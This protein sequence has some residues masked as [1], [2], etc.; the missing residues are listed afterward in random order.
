MYYKSMDMNKKNRGA[1]PMLQLTFPLAMEQ[2]FR[3]LVSTADTLM[4]SGY[5]NSA[6]AGVAVTAQYVFF[7]NLIFSVIATGCSI[8]LSQYIGAQKHKEELNHIAQASAVMMVLISIVLTVAVI[9]GTGPILS[10]YDLEPAV[11][12]SAT[13]YFVIFGGICCFFNAFSLLQGSILRTYGYTKE[14][15]I[16]SI[17]ANIINV[18]GNAISI[19]G[20]FGLP[21]TGVAGVAWSS[22]ISMIVSFFMFIYYI[23]RR[24]DV[25]FSLK[26]I[27]NVPIQS[28]RKVLS[29]GIPTAGESLSYNI[30]QIL[31]MKMITGLGT[32]AIAA[33]NYTQTVMR[34]VFAIAISIGNAT[35]IKAG[36]LVGSKQSDVA[37]KKVI[38][39]QL[40]ATACSTSLVI[41]ANIFKN[42]IISLFPNIPELREYMKIL[43]T[44]S[45][46]IEIGRTLNL[47]YVGALKGAG[48]I[49][50]PVFYGIFSMWGIM[51]L[52]SWIFGI[53]LGFGLAAFYLSIGT[54]ETTRGIVMLFR[55]KSKRWKKHA[56]V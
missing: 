47:V 53:K 41:L 2:I 16:T 20:W 4:L 30:S 29:V 56:L 55:W 46:Y 3:V 32:N 10:L 51:V 9:F 52:G 12:S 21:V 19:Y 24:K 48:D 34:F 1:L 7:L 31:I 36:Y 22:G 38:K 6:A 33:Q 37:Y 18:L 23:K 43:F 5:D 8:V 11:R 35:Q 45:I 25:Q 28:Y 17:V 44:C 15:M 50:F 27:L 40:I 13:T 42:P 49:K 39:Y 14:A 26:K 54:D